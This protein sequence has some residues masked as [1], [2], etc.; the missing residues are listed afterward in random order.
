MSRLA[1]VT[2]LVP[3]AYP[4]TRTRSTPIDRARDLNTAFA[5]PSVRAIIAVIGG[6]DQITVIPHLDAEVARA[7]S[8]PF[9]GYSD[10]TTC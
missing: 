1:E 7:D 9:L 2:G 4:S 10:N 5:D 3:V 8:K 6:D